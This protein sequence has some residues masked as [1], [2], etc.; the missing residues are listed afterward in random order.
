MSD[1]NE[2]KMKIQ[3]DIRHMGR[4]GQTGVY[5]GKFLRMFIY[6][7]GWVVIPMAAIVAALVGFALGPK[8]GVTREGTLAGG[9]AVV[10]V[11]LWN[12]SFNSIQVICRERDVLKRE[13]RS[14]MHVSSYIV[15]HMIYQFLICLLQVVLSVVIFYMVGLKFT[16]D[17]LITS[18]NTVD[19]TIT[20]FLITYA[21]DMM[22]LFISALV[23]NTTAAMTVMPFMLIFQLVF[24]G[25]LFELPNVV[26]PVTYLTISSPGFRAVASQINVNTKPIE[27]VEKMFKSLDKVDFDIKLTNSDILSMLSDDS[28][29]SIRELRNIRVG[30]TMTVRELGEL[31]L[32]DDN[33]RDFRNKTLVNRITYKDA[34]NNIANSND[35]K[36][37]DFKNTPIEENASI[38][39]VINLIL[40]DESTKDIR[41]EKIY[42]SL[43]FGQVFSA[44]LIVANESPEI[45][46]ILNDGVGVSTNVGEVIN[47]IN[48][49]SSFDY[50]LN[51]TLLDRTSMGDGLNI[52]MNSNNDIL[53]TRI[54][55]HTTLG[56]VID[57]LNS[58]NEL[59]QYKDNQIVYKTTLGEVLDKVG[60]EETMK[61]ISKASTE[62]SSKEAYTRTSFN[63]I[64]NWIHLLIFIIV[65][66]IASIITLEFID[67]DKR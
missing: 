34:L 22:S 48:S 43:T 12:G 59:E 2:K 5:F 52:L 10:C 18:W 8:F 47:Y 54:E 62:A 58:S 16:G 4:V 33:F 38:R 28:N 49:Q 17:G 32:T 42:N 65:C 9:F 50:I 21:A 35:S 20:L 1:G 15:A 31:L 40:Y 13:H 39:D 19:V 55:Y 29:E 53:N 44:I 45:N 30:K 37:V 24:S 41:D 7:S 51:E 25:G 14:G 3:L 60:R 66:S 11:C 67:R 64:V 6:Q 63:V 36:A 26:K 27:A 57:Y 46:E 23:K 61:K 56:E